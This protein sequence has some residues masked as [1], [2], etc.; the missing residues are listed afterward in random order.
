MKYKFKFY[1][2][3]L[4]HEGKLAVQITADNDILAEQIF[5]K[6]YSN[7]LP[8]GVEILRYLEDNPNY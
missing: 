8:F 5:N 3:V 6:T 2:N 1:S 4:L 7:L